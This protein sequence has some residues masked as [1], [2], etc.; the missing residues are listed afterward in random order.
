MD[1]TEFEEYFK[2]ILC[3][4][5]AEYKKTVEYEEIIDA[6]IKRFTEFSNSK[7]G[8][9]Y[10]IEHIQNSISLRSQK[11]SLIKDKFTV[12]KAILDYTLKSKTEVGSKEDIFMEIS[13]LIEETK[14]NII[15]PKENLKIST[16]IDSKIDEIL[17]KSKD[18][19]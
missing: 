2:E 11:Q 10:L 18:E 4:I 9:H 13:K 3:E 14:N 12:K 1:R 16:E 8:Q 19:D 6:E 7:G 17:G 15:L 5:D